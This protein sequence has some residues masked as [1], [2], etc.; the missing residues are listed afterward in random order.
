LQKTYLHCLLTYSAF[1]LTDLQVFAGFNLRLLLVRRF[2]GLANRARDPCLALLLVRIAPSI[3]HGPLDAQFPAK[4]SYR[5][6]G[7]HTLASL[8][9]EFWRKDAICL[10]DLLWFSKCSLAWWFSFDRHGSLP[11]A[12][13]CH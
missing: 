5:C 2:A 9:F 4:L 12:A 13:F 1:E 11:F 3:Q 6:A 7:D 8:N 10:S